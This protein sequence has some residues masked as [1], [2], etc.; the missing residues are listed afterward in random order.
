M[1]FALF[2]AFSRA[3]TSVLQR[4]ANVHG[5]R[6]EEVCMGHHALSRPATHV[7]DGVGVHGRHARLHRTG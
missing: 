5:L 7:A 3:L 4:L 6:E 1:V 2:G